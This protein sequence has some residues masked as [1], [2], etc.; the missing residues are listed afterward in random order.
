M[1]NVKEE[2]KFSYS[3]CDK[4]DGTMHEVRS[5]KCKVS[6]NVDEICEMFISFMESAGF[7]IDNVYNYFNE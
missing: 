2:I 6:V 7:S 5:A 4:D 3:F 1:D